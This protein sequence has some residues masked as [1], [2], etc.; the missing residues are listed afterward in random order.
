MRHSAIVEIDRAE[1]L[2][3]LL[4]GLAPLRAEPRARLSD[5]AREHFVLS[6]E[7]SQTQGKWSPWPY[8]IGVMDAMSHPDIEEVT[9]MKSART[10]YTKMLLASI[11]YDAAHLRANQAIWSP[12][13]GDSEIFVKSELDPMLRDV[14]AM[15]AVFPSDAQRSKHNTLQRKQFLGSALFMRGGKA[16]KNFRALTLRRAKIDELDGFDQLVEGAYDP[17]TGARKRLEGA[18]DGKLVCGST[19][20]VAGASHIETADSQ[21]SARMRY[22]LA[23]PHCQAEHYLSFGGKDQTWGFKWQGHDETTVRHVCP[24]CLQSIDQGQSIAAAKTGAWVSDC[25]HYRYGQDQ[26]WRDGLGAICP[27]PRHV[28]FRVWTAYSEQTTWAEIVREFLQAKAQADAGS[29]GKLIGFVNETLGEPWVN[30]EAEKVEAHQ[31]KTHCSTYTMGSVPQEALVLVAG[32]DVQNSWFEVSVWA[33]GRADRRWLIDHVKLPANPADE[34]DWARVLDP[35]L[36]ESTWKHAGGQLLRLDGAGID[37]MGHYT[38]QGYNYVRMREHRRF[39]GL[40]GDNQPG[41]PIGG[42]PTLQDV[43]HRGKIVKRGVKLWYVGTDTAKDLIFG[44]LQIPAPGPGYVAFPADT[45][46]EY[47]E[48]ITSENRVPVRVSGGFATRWVKIKSNARNE[49]LD[50]AVYAEFVFHRLGVHT[51]TDAAWSR[52]ESAMQ[53]DLFA[54]AQKA[55]DASAG[56]AQ[57]KAAQEIY[58]ARLPARSATTAPAARPVGRQW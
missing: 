26:E 19:P 25:G 8:Q 24:H 41:K 1:I 38:H 3:A 54:Q 39:F 20:R 58:P 50:T 14:V 34:A 51:Y 42:R 10:G 15:R 35:F 2:R 27:P 5:W 23:C 6:A 12:T 11:A 13:D 30:D 55:V 40:R 37:M 31:L 44:R 48:G 21:A 16:S 53:P 36:V 7:S 46:A 49:P 45:P 57:T 33:A 17:R 22:H 28:S 18:F 29:K 32:V 43:N 47:F 4:A 52:L 9:L 56:P